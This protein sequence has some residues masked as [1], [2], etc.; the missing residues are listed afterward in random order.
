LRSGATTVSKYAVNKVMREVNMDPAALAAYR[1]DSA[2]FVRARPGL[3]LDERAALADKDYGSLYALGAHPYLLW[4]FIEAALV[5]P[6]TRPE[7]VD[8][9]RVAASAVGYP[10]FAT[11]PAPSRE[12]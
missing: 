12:T 7:L 11:T 5:P 8:S 3:T 10:D 6:R 4:S 9:F 2:G 1:A